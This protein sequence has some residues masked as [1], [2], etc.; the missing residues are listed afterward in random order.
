MQIK[1]DY[2]YKIHIIPAKS[3]PGCFTV[4]IADKCSHSVCP[5]TR[6][7]NLL[8]YT[9]FMYKGMTELTLLLVK[10]TVWV[11][12]S[13]E[14]SNTI[15]YTHNMESTRWDTAD[16]DQMSEE[17]SILTW[18]LVNSETTTR[19]RPLLW[20]QS[21]MKPEIFTL[22]WELEAIIILIRKVLDVGL[23]TLEY[24]IVSTQ[25]NDGKWVWFQFSSPEVT[26]LT[27]HASRSRRCF[28]RWRTFS[29]DPG[30]EY[31]FWFAQLKTTLY[32]RVV[33][34]RSFLRSGSLWLEPLM[35]VWCFLVFAGLHGS[36][37]EFN[38]QL[39]IPGF[40]AID[41]NV[42]PA[43]TRVHLIF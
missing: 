19:Q 30:F 6:L 10:H 35:V 7:F 28:H 40:V 8:F 3:L 25:E 20:I 11:P 32:I 39:M 12:I 43:P 16:Q 17:Y 26:P 33:L 4:T 36:C 23:R 9:S 41:V 1:S 21:R 38:L 34:S 5:S 42:N 15:W 18:A 24:A 2:K 29:G 22:L 37:T 31:W 27:C 14:W 13:T